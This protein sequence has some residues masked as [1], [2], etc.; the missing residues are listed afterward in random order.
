MGKKKRREQEK[1]DGYSHQQTDQQKEQVGA[2]QEEGGEQVPW[3]NGE[4]K[5]GKGLS[6]LCFGFWMSL[7]HNQKLE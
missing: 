6:C 2:T 4:L 1:E 7:P 3:E 5:R